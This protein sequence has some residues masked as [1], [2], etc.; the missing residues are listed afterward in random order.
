MGKDSQL[1]ADLFK[2]T[3][4]QDF[5]VEHDGEKTFYGMLEGIGD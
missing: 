2:L 1:I 5:P 3:W 4:K